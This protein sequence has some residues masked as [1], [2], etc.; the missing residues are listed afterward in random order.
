MAVPDSGEHPKNPLRQRRTNDSD[1]AAKAGFRNPSNKRSKA[2][3]KKTPRRK[4]R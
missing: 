2:S 3:R 4:S 1:V